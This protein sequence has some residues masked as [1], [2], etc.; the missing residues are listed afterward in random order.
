MLVKDIFARDVTRD[1]APVVYFHEQEPAKLWEEVSEYIITGGYAENDPRHTRTNQGI[2]EQFVRLLKAIAQDLEQP[3]RSGTTLPAAW[4]SGFYGSGKS[5]FAKLLGLALDD[6]QMPNGQKL[7]DALLSRDDSPKSTEF[8]E[9]W[10]KLTKRIEAIAVVFDIGSLA[11]ENED[12]HQVAKR[13]IQKRLGYCKT[14]NYVAEHELKLEIDG[15][16]DAFLECAITTIGKPWEQIK[17]SEL[18]EED[19]SLILHRLEPEK[20][21]EPMSWIDSR[22]GSRTG[23]GSAVDETT[24]AIA[25]MLNR[26][27]PSKT[28]FITIDEVSQYIHQNDNRMLKLQSFVEDLGQK[29]KG[30][31][32]L[33]ATG[34]QQLEDGIDQGNIGKLKDRFPPRFRVHLTPANIRDVVHKRLLQKSPVH[35]AELRNLFQQ[36]RSDLKLYAYGCENISEEDFLEVYPLLPNYID[37]FMQITSSLRLT[38]TRVKGDD[39]AVRGLLQMLGELFRTQ[40]LGDRKLGALVTIDAIYEIQQTALDVDTQNT[41]TRILGDREIV[42]DQLALKVAK[43]IAL[44]QL[45]QESQ[46]TTAKLISQCLYDSL[47]VGNNEPEIQIALDKLRDRGH[48]TYS[49][50]LGYKLQ[51]SAGQEWQRERDSEGVNDEKMTA[52]LMEKLKVL[53]GDTENPKYKGRSFRW[54]AYFSD[55]RQRK[56]ERLISPNDVATAIV[57]LRYIRDDL[58]EDVTIWIAQTGQEAYRDR[59]LWVVGN[60][61]DIPELARRQ[62]RSRQM[63][64]KYQGRF[65]ALSPNKQRLLI[66]E[67]SEADRLDSILKEAI[68]NAFVRGSFYFRGRQL[69]AQGLTFSSLLQHTAESILPDVYPHFQDMAIAPSELEQLFKKQLSGVSQKFMERELGILSLDAGKYVPTCNGEIPTLI[70]EAIARNNGLA[71]S[72]LL[73]IFGSAPYGYAS[74]LVRACL[75]GLLRANKIR[76]RTENQQ[77]IS[78]YADVGVED[79]FKKE[80]DLKKAEIL[81]STESDITVRDRNAICKFFND[82]LQVELDREKEAIADAVFKYFPYKASLLREL[83]GKYNRLP[84]RL[85]DVADQNYDDRHQLPDSLQ[86]LQKALTDCCQSRQIE[87]TVRAVKR[88]LEVL[89]DG[90]QRLSIENSELTNEAIA[91]VKKAH[92]VYIHCVEQLRGMG[93]LADL[94]PMAIALRQQLQAERPWRDLTSLTPSIEAIALR[95]REVRHDLLDAQYLQLE[96][97]AARVKTRHGFARLSEEKADYVIRPIRQAEIKTT[98]D[99]LYPTLIQLRDSAIRQLEQAEMEANATL[100]R[101]ISEET[102]EQ[103][104]TLD[105]LT[106]LRNRELRNPDEVNALVDTF[107][108]RLLKQLENKKNIRIRLI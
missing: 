67:Q 98:I 79:L 91:Q 41:M 84:L 105:V 88:H 56:D 19:F 77:M 57:D 58:K 25:A 68:S 81:L 48:I 102:Q 26:R 45:I 39:Y 78:S 52:I 49:E 46:P 17:N 83:E 51:S 94:E 86:K 55:E 100:D 47:G 64:S 71:G 54:Q 33:L 69:D 53:I 60:I 14:S 7:A 99:A 76:I 5:S 44:L 65:A 27:A 80:R 70:Y 85:Q 63:I 30:R 21:I 37:L 73:T 35:E 23:L 75:L 1:I 43:A 12:I 66:E 61:S 16:W 4:I 106:D 22:A 40:G 62:V 34:Q 92:D 42:G 6:R 36:H 87:D 2:H 96:A 8:K 32:W 50:K 3:N 89:Q 108:D 24:K 97:V 103:V 93:K 104:L 10:Q 90:M 74:D 13:E 101:L 20:Y 107:R 95:Y 11:R 29:L 9:A 28:L 82:Y 18:A 59:L 72:S 31:V 38:S 15:R